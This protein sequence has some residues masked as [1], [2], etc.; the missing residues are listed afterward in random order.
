[1]APV[2]A[3]VPRTHP[4][5]PL[6]LLEALQNLDTPYGDDLHE[7]ADE[8]LSRRLGLSGTV[9]AQ[10]ARYARRRG[11]VDAAEAVSLFSLLGRRP[12]HEVLFADAGRRAARRA[13]SPGG[14]L[15]SRVAP[16]RLGR[17]VGMR[18]ARRVLGRVF[19]GT[20]QFDG[21][22]PTIMLDDPLS[23][24]GT[25]DGRGCTF[26][27]AAFAEVLRLLAGFEGALQHETCKAQGAEECRWSGA[28]PSELML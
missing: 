9:A 27:G 15:L 23:I 1:M 8:L 22:V 6:A 5:I 13:I 19:D 20:M 12:D 2:K 7:I 24:R 26:Y 21:S 10:A 28:I 14:K 4:V 25:G 16:R 11:R 17:R 18:V 3:A